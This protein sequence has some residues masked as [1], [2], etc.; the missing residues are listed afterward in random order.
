V[1]V[2]AWDLRPVDLGF[3][4]TAQYSLHCREVVPHPAPD[5]WASFALDPAGWGRWFPGFSE[6]GHYLEADQ[7]GLGSVREVWMGGV[8]YKET[9]IGWSEPDRFAFCVTESG[10]PIANALAEDYQ[11]VEY[12]QGRSVVE[13]TFAADPKPMLKPLM[14]AMPRL[15][16]VVFR[17][18]MRRLSA[19]LSTSQGSRL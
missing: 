1:F 4:E 16:P 9:V 2:V 15:M 3:F 10:A 17:K 11:I 5:I 12:Q 7:P 19:R 18:A 8:H 13:W 6:A 14:V